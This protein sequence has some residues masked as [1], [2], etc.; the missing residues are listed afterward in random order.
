[1]SEISLEEASSEHEAISPEILKLNKTNEFKRN[2]SPNYNSNKNKINEEQIFKNCKISRKRKN[3]LNDEEISNATATIEKDIQKID[4]KHSCSLQS[5]NSKNSVESSR[6]ATLNNNLDLNGNVISDENQINQDWRKNKRKQYRRRDN[7]T[8]KLGDY[9]GD[10]LI[11][12]PRSAR[13]LLLQKNSFHDQIKTHS[14][15]KESEHEISN[16]LENYNE[17]LPEKDIEV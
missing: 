3:C 1:M 15:E 7:I 11:D 13:K 5:L 4:R 9:W 8:N 16:E 17:N 12:I 10:N 14:S 2:K 6:I